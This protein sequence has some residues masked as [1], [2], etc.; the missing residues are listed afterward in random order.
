MSSK[1]SLAFKLSFG[2][3]A[4]TVDGSIT[5]PKTFWESIYKISKV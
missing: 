2:T 1:Y 5:G 4:P 3:T